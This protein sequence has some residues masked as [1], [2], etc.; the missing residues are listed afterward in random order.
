[1]AL[2]IVVTSFKSS[3]VATGFHK[4]RFLVILNLQWIYTY[5]NIC[6]TGKGLNIWDTQTHNHPEYVHD[7]SN[8]DIAAD[9]YHKYAEDIKLL[10][11]LGVST[12]SFLSETY[13]Y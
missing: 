4:V 12:N 7:F 3:K 11:D 8:G 10:K 1:V 5:A 6:F 13:I 2:Q 9:S